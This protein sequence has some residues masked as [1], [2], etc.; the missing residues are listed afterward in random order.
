MCTLCGVNTQPVVL[1]RCYLDINPD[2]QI[3]NA[4][5]NLLQ[6]TFISIVYTFMSLSPS[7]LSYHAQ[8]E[9]RTTELKE[10]YENNSTFYQTKHFNVIYIYPSE[11]DATI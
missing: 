11:D 5:L 3:T 6:L 9:I 10:Q 7:L 4:N 1:L 2:K 8:T